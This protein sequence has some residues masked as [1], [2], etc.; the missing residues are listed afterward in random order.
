MVVGQPPSAIA[1]LESYRECAQQTMG[2]ILNEVKNLQLFKKLVSWR[3]VASFVLT[4][5]AKQATFFGFRCSL[6][7]TK[8]NE[9]SKTRQEFLKT[10]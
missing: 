10:L 8:Q 4:R 9:V 1:F 7:Q 2:V 3:A 5:K 6:T